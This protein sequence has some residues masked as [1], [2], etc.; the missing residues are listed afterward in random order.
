MR[1]LGQGLKT[2][3]TGLLAVNAVHQLLTQLIAELPAGKAQRAQRAL[4]SGQLFSLHK[5]VKRNHAAGDLRIV[6]AVV[7]LRYDIQQVADNAAKLPGGLFGG[8]LPVAHA[9]TQRRKLGQ[10]P[11][12][13]GNAPA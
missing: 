11:H 7:E 12:R 6:D 13:A 1:R 8:N 5:A 10:I 2:V 3:E 9:F 4:L